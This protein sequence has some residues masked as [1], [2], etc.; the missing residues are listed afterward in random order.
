M[1]NKYDGAF[2]YARTPEVPAEALPAIYKLAREA[3]FEPQ[4]FCKVRNACGVPKQLG[5]E[6]IGVPG[7]LA[8]EPNR[9]SRRGGLGGLEAAA[10]PPALPQKQNPLVLSSLQIWYE[11][12]DYLEDPHYAGSYLLRNQERMPPLAKAGPLPAAAT[13]GGAAGAQGR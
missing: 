11:L 3:G 4:S 1:Q 10:N 12:T 7:V 9:D 8:D 6:L 2:V 13:A 5:P